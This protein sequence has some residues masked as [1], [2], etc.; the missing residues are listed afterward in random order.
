[1]HVGAGGG[2]GGPV[3][4][5]LEGERAA[6]ADL[7]SGKNKETR[8]EASSVPPREQDR[9]EVALGD[10]SAYV[11]TTEPQS[12]EERA[13]WSLRSPPVAP[14]ALPVGLVPRDPGCDHHK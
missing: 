2:F 11:S 5:A 9:E 7:P 8:P 13:N 14:V 10:T 1:M 4:G 6:A 12:Q 3:L